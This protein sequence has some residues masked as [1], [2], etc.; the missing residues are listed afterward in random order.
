MTRRDFL[1]SAFAALG[2]AALPGG[3]FAVPRGWKPPKTP[4]LVFG[5]LS[6]THLQVNYDGVNPHGRFPLKHLRKALEYFK[7]RNIDALVHCG[8]MAHRGMVRELEFHQEL[9]DEVFGKGRGPVKLF[10]AGNHEWFGDGEGFGGVC[11]RRLYPDAAERAKHTV[12]GDFPGHWERVF[13][14][15]YEECWHKEV[16]G[17]H[18]F[19]HQWG[20]DEMKFLEFVKSEAAVSS[21]CGAQ[22]FFLLS[23]AYFHYRFCRLLS[24]DYPR[25]IGLFGHYHQS[26]A[27]WRTIYYDDLGGFFPQ[28]ELGPCRADGGLDMYGNL[29]S[30]S[31]SSFLTNRADAME[32]VKSTPT[33]SRQGMVVSVYDDMIVFERHE[34]TDGGKIGPDWVLP[35]MH[36]TEKHPFS[37]EELKKIIGEPQF[38]KSVKLKVESVKAKNGEDAVKILIPLADGNPDSRVY[39]YEVVVVGD[40]GTPKLFKAVYAAGCNMGIGHEPNGGVT[41][42]EI[43]KDELPPGKTLTVAVRPLTSLGTY[44]RPLSTEFHT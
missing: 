21:L 33:P 26:N 38:G 6:D 34:F 22:P 17:C 28:M 44:G 13:G 27:D 1:G 39:A 40:A 11:G 12:C 24:K 31:E 5:A 18:F 29:G 15:L 36:E 10:V 19:G 2:F 7:R 16:K 35:L 3:L 43:P 30:T 37:R 8:D 4:N 20:V 42:L 25:A 23:H 32:I 9:I 14:E 41:T